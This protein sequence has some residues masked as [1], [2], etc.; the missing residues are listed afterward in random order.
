MSDNL[1]QSVEHHEVIFGDRY[2]VDSQASIGS[3]GFAD[4]YLG[5][6]TRASESS[7]GHFA[8]KVLRTLDDD[9]EG[10][11]I[12]RF[13]REI[14]LLSDVKHRHVIPILDSGTDPEDRHWYA[15]PLASGCLDDDL[16][17][18]VADDLQIAD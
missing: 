17:Q 18:F 5:V 14:R 6:D 4:V 12:A 15:M 8:V 1:R 13:M 11:I 10:E 9:S 3:G 16:A 7:A 2:R